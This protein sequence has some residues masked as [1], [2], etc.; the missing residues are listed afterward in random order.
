MTSRARFISRGQSRQG[1]GLTC[2]A[3][4]ANGDVV[5][6]NDI[7]EIRMFSNKIWAENKNWTM[8]GNEG[9]TGD[10]GTGQR[11]IAKTR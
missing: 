4:S 5:I 2:A 9:V 1:A 6:G 8:H 3:T 11:L 10:I 7:G